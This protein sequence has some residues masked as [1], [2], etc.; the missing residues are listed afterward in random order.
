MER[1]RLTAH[2]EMRGMFAD[3]SQRFKAL[4]EPGKEEVKSKEYAAWRR[5]KALHQKCVEL[6]KE[7]DAV[8]KAL[9]ELLQEF[10]KA[11]VELE[12]GE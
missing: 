10:K 4:P 3:L 6:R 5:A 2:V 9:W 8:L 11:V 7:E 12:N 1:I